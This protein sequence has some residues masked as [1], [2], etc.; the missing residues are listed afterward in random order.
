MVINKFTRFLWRQFSQI[1]WPA[2]ITLL[3][4]HAALS[5]LLL[6]WAGEEYLLAFHE[7][8]YYYVVTTSTVGYGDLSPASDA[9]K[10]IVALVQIPLGLAI[11]G[12]LLGKLGQSIS[13]VLRKVM[14]GEKDFR[15]LDTHILIFGWH[16][17]RTSK[18][19]QHIL[20]DNKR[21]Q[22]KILLCVTKDME[23]PFYDNSMVEFAKLKSFTDDEE[24]K[25]V[26]A[27]EA[28]RVI[29][30]CD[31]DD[32]T[33]TCAL[34]LSKIVASDCHITAYFDEEEKAVMLN[35]YT[36]NV[37]ASYS[38]A[39]EI[40]VRSMQDPGSSKLQE[41][42]MSTLQGETQFS[43]EIPANVPSSQ[44][45]EL[46]YYFKQKHDAILLAVAKDRIGLDMKLNPDNDFEVKPGYILH[47][48]SKQRL[49]PNEI[50]WQAASEYTNKGIK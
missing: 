38:K 1:T 10:M 48:V 11:F 12:A 34:K 19:I 14:T 25:R 47:Y 27:D 33:F 24:L 42:L 8:L 30:D 9:G 17:K 26:A 6:L 28:D 13:K 31:N 2:I 4:L 40:L 15:Y 21:M 7:F 37:E 5:W 23:H 18:I 45:G 41:E 36:T 46:F 29:V 39:A 43:T 50:N 22:R 44:F 32:K 35:N 20:G 3:V 16:E 49:M